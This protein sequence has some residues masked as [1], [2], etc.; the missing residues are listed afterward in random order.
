MGG[1]KS[2]VRLRI[3]ESSSPEAHA[4]PRFS[5]IIRLLGGRAGDNADFRMDEA[6]RFSGRKRD[7]LMSDGMR[8]YQQRTSGG[9]I[10]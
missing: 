7:Q 3:P 8:G 10:N 1:L 9:L 5:V 6:F 4:P 2:R